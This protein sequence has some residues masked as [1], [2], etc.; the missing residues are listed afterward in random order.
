MLIFVVSCIMKL[1]VIKTFFVLLKDL[2]CFVVDILVVFL[3]YKL[4]C[5]RFLNFMV[6]LIFKYLCLYLRN[7]Y[8][9]DNVKFI[10]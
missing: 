10:G 6:V 9:N 4:I 1:D 5:I 2:I 8:V 7:I 3:D